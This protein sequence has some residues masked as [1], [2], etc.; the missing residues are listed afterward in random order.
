MLIKSMAFNE[1][2]WSM[3]YWAHGLRL[4]I[5]EKKIAG[6][7]FVRKYDWVVLRLQL[8]GA[9]V[10]PLSP[11]KTSHCCSIRSLSFVIYFKVRV[12]A[13]LRTNKI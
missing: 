9:L 6:G 3:F 5:Y 2:Y 8:I 7:H 12:R 13:L 1:C 4:V 11:F 10:S